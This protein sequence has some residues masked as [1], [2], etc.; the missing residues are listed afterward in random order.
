MALAPATHSILGPV[1]R[2]LADAIYG[3]W[4][5]RSRNWPDDKWTR[6]GRRLKEKIAAVRGKLVAVPA[7]T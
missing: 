6:R 7:T 2:T 5:W 3:L 1:L 4:W